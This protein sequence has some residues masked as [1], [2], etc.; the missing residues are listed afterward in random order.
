MQDGVFWKSS[1]QRPLN[2][3]GRNMSGKPVKPDATNLVWLYYQKNVLTSTLFNLDQRAII[4]HVY[5]LN[6]IFS[7]TFKNAFIFRTLFN[8]IYEYL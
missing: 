6:H 8:K 1:Q 2:V 3:V 5:T 7:N 4:G